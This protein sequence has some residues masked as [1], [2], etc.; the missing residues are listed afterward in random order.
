MNNLREAATVREDGCILIGQ[1]VT[2]DGFASDRSIRVQTS[3]N[4]L[5]DFSTSKGSQKKI[6]L[7]QETYDELLKQSSDIKFRRGQF[8][9]LPVNGVYHTVENTQISFFPSGDIVG[10]V[11]PV[12]LTE[13]GTTIMY[14]PYISWSPS[15]SEL[16]FP[17][18]DVL[19]TDIKSINIDTEGDH[20]NGIVSLIKTVKPKLVVTYSSQNGNASLLAEYI[21]GKLGVQ[22]ICA[23]K[24]IGSA[25]SNTDE[26][27]INQVVSSPIP[28]VA[29]STLKT[30]KRLIVVVTSENQNKEG[31]NPLVDELKKET[32]LI[33]AEWLI[34]DNH[35]LHDKSFEDGL[36]LSI[37]LK[38]KI[39][40]RWKNDE[41]FEEVILIGH[42]LGGILVRQAYLLASGTS[43]GYDR[44]SW[45]EYVR[46]LVLFAS[47]NRGLD[48]NRSLISRIV[49]AFSQY[50]SSS[51]RKLIPLQS[52][53]RGSAFISNLRIDWIRHFSSEFYYPLVIIQLLGTKDSNIT[54]KDSID[55]E[56]FPDA[57]HID[58][59][60]ARNSN[61][62][63]IDLAEDREERY[64]IIKMA[65]LSDYPSGLSSDENSNMEFG[66]AIMVGLIK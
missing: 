37:D 45:Y 54:R 53:A 14:S 6:V 12:I 58:V 47:P 51:L 40:A 22:S 32:T 66:Q 60:D 56:Q 4:R 30:L 26:T 27:R 16:S 3:I 48:P 44:S 17:K 42:S 41:S 52:F 55:L 13:N 23:N 31:W 9:V 38:A 24:F 49:M 59:P 11:I 15:L 18:V 2:C 34:W 5:D 1:T 50:T 28:Q 62:H 65:I 10:E 33:D 39:D 36:S 35:N 29:S 57:Y 25:W 63:Q 8:E 7:S 64:K 46:R 43:K 61:I 21:H 20:F 19:I